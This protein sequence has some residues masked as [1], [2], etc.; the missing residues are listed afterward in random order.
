MSARWLDVY[1]YRMLAARREGNRMAV[2]QWADCI[3]INARADCT[4]EE[5]LI[6]DEM[7]ARHAAN[8]D[9]VATVRAGQKKG[10]GE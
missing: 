9:S 7:I 3:A 8:A 2:L 10:A 5:R 4:P 6:Y 1:L